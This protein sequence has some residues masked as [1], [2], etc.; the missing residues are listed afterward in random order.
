MK[1]SIKSEN[2]INKMRVAGR[3]AADVL[4]MITPYVIPGI[5]T[6]ELDK[7]CYEYIAVSYTHLTLPTKRIV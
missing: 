6:G 4:E 2:E 1:I 3:L 7:I 5:S